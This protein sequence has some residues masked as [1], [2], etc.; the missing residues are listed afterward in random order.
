M[1]LGLNTSAWLWFLLPAMLLFPDLEGF[2]ACQSLKAPSALPGLLC[3][4]GL[5][6]L[7]V[8]YADIELCICIL[9]LEH[10]EL[11]GSLSLSAV[12]A[13]PPQLA[14]P[15][16]ST[17]PRQGLYSAASGPR[18]NTTRDGGGCQEGVVRAA[19]LCCCVPLL[20]RDSDDV[21]TLP[22]L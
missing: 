16:D 5:P 4:L 3:C 7:L 9:R 22:P 1:Q 13:P 18:V 12:V 14:V 6:A 10:T 20:M 17:P 19:V 8:S 15:W 2:P 11:M 21:K